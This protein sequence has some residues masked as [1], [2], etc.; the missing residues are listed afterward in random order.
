MFI[1]KSNIVKLYYALQ[2]LQVHLIGTWWN[3]SYYYS[4]SYDEETEAQNV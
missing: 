3:R 2:V 1:M 4:H